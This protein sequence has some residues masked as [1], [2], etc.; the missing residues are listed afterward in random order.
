MN[1]DDRDFN[2]AVGAQIQQARKRAG[3]TQAELA[4]QGGVS[5]VAVSNLERGLHGCRLVVLFRLAAALRVPVS[6]LVPTPVCGDSLPFP[7]ENLDPGIREV[8]RVLRDAGFVTTDSGDGVSK[9]ENPPEWMTEDPEGC[10]VLRIPHVFMVA[11]SGEEGVELCERLLMLLELYDITA[12][13][14]PADGQGVWVQMTYDPCS[15]R[16]TTIGLFGVTSE[17]VQG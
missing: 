15:P 5:R 17:M 11:R 2:Q 14:V 7:Y 9:W 13:S 1:K 6:S 10:G 4:S 3:L 16:L 8:V 12:K